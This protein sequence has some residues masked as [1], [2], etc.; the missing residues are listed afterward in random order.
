[1]GPGL[2]A[3]AR[4]AMSFEILCSEPWA[5]AD[6]GRVRRSGAGSYLAGVAGSRA[7]LFAAACR[8][9]PRG[10]VPAGEAEPVPTDVPVLILAG[11]ADPQDPPANMR[12]WRTLF[13]H[14]RL[15]V[16]RGAT[17]GVLAEGCVALL[18]ARFVERGTARGLDTACARRIEQPPF[19]LP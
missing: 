8:F 5:R 11:G 12:G 19:V 18:A 4:L 13:P 6:P 7:R 9:V 14:G 17:H 1:M 10:V 3:R 15:V 2:D 16:V